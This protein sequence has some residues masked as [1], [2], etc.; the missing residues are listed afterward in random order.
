MNGDTSE[1]RILSELSYDAQ[2]GALRYQGVRYLLI[3]PE[4]LAAVQASLEVQ[5][6][7]ALAGE[8]LFQGGFTGGRLSGQKYKDSFGLSDEQAV[9][10]MCRMGSEIGWGRISLAEFDLGRKRMVVEVQ[11]SPFAEA[12]GR[13]SREGVCHLIRGVF[14]GLASTLFG[15]PVRAVEAICLAAGQAQ[16]RF[17]IEAEA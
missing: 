2:A 15:A 12:Y 16:C 7:P 10:F 1:N 13:G 3:R 11:H 8:I 6:G 17:E 5:L 4:T 9:L 14:A